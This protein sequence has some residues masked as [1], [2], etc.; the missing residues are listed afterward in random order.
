MANI[1]TTHEPQVIK[2]ETMHWGKKKKA[3]L[4]KQISP[5]GISTQTEQPSTLQ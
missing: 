5:E 3:T 1:L 4:F 2:Y